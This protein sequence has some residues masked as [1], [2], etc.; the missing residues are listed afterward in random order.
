M[1]CAREPAK[2]MLTHPV[3]H[4]F[5]LHAPLL[6]QANLD[7]LKWC[8]NDEGLSDAG[9]EASRQPASF[10]QVTVLQRHLCQ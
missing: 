3:A 1:A 8:H 7:N 5:P 6:L 9:A 10:C 2:V 4:V